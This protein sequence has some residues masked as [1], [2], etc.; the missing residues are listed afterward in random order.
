MGAD[1]VS[2]ALQRFSRSLPVPGPENHNECTVNLLSSELRS[3]VNLYDYRAPDNPYEAAR[4]HKHI[5]LVHRVVITPSGTHLEG[6]DPGPA[7]RVLRQYADFIDHFIRVIFTDEDGGS[8]RYDPRASHRVVY[9]ERF[10][11]VLNGS[12]IIAGRGFDFLG[13]SHSALRG[14]SCWF[15]APIAHEGTLFFAAH[16]LK[17]LGNFETIRTPAKCATRIGQNFTDTNDTINLDQSS[18]GE[19]ALVTRNGYDFG[20]GVGTVSQELLSEIWRVNGTKRLL[21]PTVLQ[22]RFQSAK[23]VVA[24]DSRLKGKQL[25]LRSN[26]KKY[27]TESSWKLEV[28][29]AAVKPLPMLLNRQLIKLLED[30]A[31]PSQVFFDLQDAAMQRP[32]FMTET[33]INTG[34]FL[35][36]SI[37]QATHISSLIWYL[38]EI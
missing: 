5:N 22:I 9:D 34:W 3:F 21:K 16:I 19:L 29:G 6:P 33:P 14:H 26:M 12:T 37:S 4:R 8:V 25:L 35:R 1:P 30:L 13:F 31:V 17:K 24:L 15:M 36:Q 11:G 10:R 27:E 2:Q 18:L 23:G 38:G 7:N 28:C 32:R 20:D